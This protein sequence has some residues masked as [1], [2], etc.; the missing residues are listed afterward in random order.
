MQPAEG[1][2]LLV[3]DD[4]TL[5]AAVEHKLE[6]CHYR[7]LHAP[8]GR[9]ALNVF[10][11][12]SPDLV[13]LDLMLPDLPGEAV[14]DSIRESST[15]PVI[16]MSAKAEESDR[17]GTLNS[18]ADDYLTKPLSLSELEARVRAVLRRSWLPSGDAE[19]V[20]DQGRRPHSELSYAGISLDL[21]GHEARL[22]GRPLEL[23][24]TEF[25]LLRTLVERGGAATSI[26]Q[27]I[28]AVWSYDGHDRHIVESNIHRLRRKIEPD[29]GT[30]QRLVTVR[31]FGYRLIDAAAPA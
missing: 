17:T 18:G 2:L 30:P 4:L 22:E 31:G 29:P 23:S 13:L 12:G 16:I 21:A 7:V 5:A 26:E 19:L 27:I 20:S 15:T 6:R 9:A 24:P 10:E 25:R 8:S 3:E 11:A 14:L 1:T 28:R